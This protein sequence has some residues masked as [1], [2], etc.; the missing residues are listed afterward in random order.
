[1]SARPRRRPRTCWRSTTPSRRRPRRR[2]KRWNCC[3][4]WPTRWW[5]KAT[6]TRLL[7]NP[8]SRK[9][10]ILT[11]IFPLG[12]INT[13]PSWRPT[14]AFSRWARINWPWTEP[15]SRVWIP[16]MPR[17]R[18]C[19]LRVNWTRATVYEVH[20]ILLDQRPFQRCEELIVVE[21]S[22]AA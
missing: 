20:Y 1:M 15:R 19:L 16:A 17:P 7:S 21:L 10:M 18:G 14:W 11:R 6:P 22:L 5:K 3:Y 4:N 8:G 2:E 12:W 9:W 13:G